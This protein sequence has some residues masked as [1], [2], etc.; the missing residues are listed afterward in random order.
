MG[1]SSEGQKETQKRIVNRLPH[2]GVFDYARIGYFSL[3]TKDTK[4][5]SRED[6]LT[7]G[8]ETETPGYFFGKFM[9]GLWTGKSNAPE[10]DLSYP[11]KAIP[12][13]Y[14]SAVYIDIRHAFRQIATAFGMEVFII[15]EGRTIAYGETTPNAPCFNDK[16]CR[17]LLVTG[18]SKTGT[19][20]E[21]KNRDISTVRFS[22][23]YYAPHL[24]H[25]I[26]STLHAIQTV[27]SPYSI[28]GHTDGCI[29][30]RRHVKKVVNIL[31]DYGFKYA[32]KGTG[33]CQVH[34]V[35]SYRVGDAETRLFLRPQGTRVYVREDNAKWWLRKY[36]EG[37]SK[38][39][40]S[41]VFE[42]G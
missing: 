19:Y 21:W 28:Y 4:F 34:G 11:Y 33:V 16:I 31:D 42:D 25:C 36:A 29:V 3:T 12:G 13:K 1:R 40:G 18:V 26:W 38:R 9:K 14:P 6:S 20:Q 15:Q 35:G 24:S 22:N 41:Y 2:Y 10:L 37:I 39:D 32:I 7:I 8:D 17:G 5:I 30:P 23:P 27:L